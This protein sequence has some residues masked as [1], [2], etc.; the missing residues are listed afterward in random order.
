M[1]LID[2]KTRKHLCWA[3][4]AKEHDRWL[5]RCSQGELR[6]ENK[7]VHECARYWVLFG[8]NSFNVISSRIAWRRSVSVSMPC[9]RMWDLTISSEKSAI[10]ETFI[11][12]W[13]W[14]WIW[15]CRYTN[16]TVP[17]GLIAEDTWK[18]TRAEHTHTNDKRLESVR[19]YPVLLK[20]IQLAF[21][22][23]VSY[24]NSDLCWLRIRYGQLKCQKE[25]RA[26]SMKAD[27]LR[28]TKLKYIRLASLIHRHTHTY[29]QAI[30]IE[31]NYLPYPNSETQRYQS[32]KRP[33]DWAKSN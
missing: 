21:Y 17:N 14:N 22:A 26:R 30:L 9:S 5:G 3:E 6:L 28:W 18:S 2:S 25:M 23:G 19:I 7:M 16:T 24:D 11:V 27:D 1:P 15:Q 8:W 10:I 4:N 29:T 32:G 31:V 13:D 12:V 20:C 33:K